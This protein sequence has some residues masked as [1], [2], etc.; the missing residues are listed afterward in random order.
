M[1]NGWDRIVQHDAVKNFAV[2]PM[3]LLIKPLKS[4]CPRWVCKK[5]GKARERI[6]KKTY[7]SAHKRGKN[8][9]HRDGTTSLTSSKAVKEGGWNELP[10][11]RIKEIETLGWSDCGCNAGFDAGV[12]LDPFCGRGTVGKVAKQLG[13]HYILFD[14]KPE[15][16]EIARLYIGGQKHKLV[17][18]QQKLRSVIICLKNTQKAHLRVC[19]I[20]SPKSTVRI[21]G[22]QI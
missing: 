7:E 13:L 1:N 19:R 3:E 20:S 5:C 17:E 2:F 11:L 6:S 4:S 12:V 21:I 18:Y 14:V 9:T 22:R 15:Y 8:Y 16:C 10:A